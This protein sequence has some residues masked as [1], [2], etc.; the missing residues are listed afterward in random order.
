MASSL[1]RNGLRS[2]TY[3]C[4][5]VR[6]YLPKQVRVKTG[7][8]AS[9]CCSVCVCVLPC[10]RACV[11]LRVCFSVSSSVCLAV[12]CVWVCACVWEYTAASLAD[13]RL[14]LLPRGVECNQAIARRPRPHV[15]LKQALF[16]TRRQHRGMSWGRTQTD[17]DTH[18]QNRICTHVHMYATNVPRTR[19]SNSLKLA[20]FPKMVCAGSKERE[21]E[22]ERGRERD[23]HT[24][25]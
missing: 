9:E 1:R 11:Y 3:S 23:R 2:A 24:T 8:L 12:L 10:L 20:M 4:T 5:L 22:R 18:R 14:S 15:L 13:T 21:V 16:C 25:T 7:H 19:T 17:T 6:L